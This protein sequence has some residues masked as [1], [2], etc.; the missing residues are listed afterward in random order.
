ML[1]KL[2][3]GKPPHGHFPGKQAQMH[4]V[5]V[6]QGVF[7]INILQYSF[8]L[9]LPCSHL[10]PLVY[11]C[12]ERGLVKIHSCERLFLI[13]GEKIRGG[14]PHLLF[15]SLVMLMYSSEAG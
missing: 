15:Q 2:G 10:L 11:D 4:P 13:F 8:W 14:V 7:L 5:P 3:T 9:Y 1:R 12:S 6:L